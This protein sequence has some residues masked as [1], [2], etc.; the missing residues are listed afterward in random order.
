MSALQRHNF[1][2]I[3]LRYFLYL[4]FFIHISCLFMVKEVRKYIEVKRM[5]GLSEFFFLVWGH[6]WIML[7]YVNRLI[8]LSFF[9]NPITNMY[10]DF[11]WG[12]EMDF[13]CGDHTPHFKCLMEITAFTR[14]WPQVAVPLCS[15][16]AIPACVCSYVIAQCRTEQMKQSRRSHFLAG[17][18]LCFFTPIPVSSLFLS[19]EAT[20]W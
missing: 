4:L 10:F 1:S 14:D 13:S 9:R 20:W 15:H 7:K 17:P 12:R 2:H 6:F 18:L 5:S 19:S 3:D 16:Y 8:N 11:Q